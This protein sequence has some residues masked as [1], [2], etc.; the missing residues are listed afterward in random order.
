MRDVRAAFAA[1]WLEVAREADARGDATGGLR[2][3][4]HEAAVRHAL[5]SDIRTAAQGLDVRRVDSAGISDVVVVPGVLGDTVRLLVA[6]FSFASEPL[7]P[8]GIRT[9]VARVNGRTGCARNADLLRG[10]VLDAAAREGRPINLVGYSKGCTDALHMLARYPDTHAALHSLVSMAGVVRGTPLAARTP[11]W[12]SNA[13]RW[14]PL[15]GVP[16]GDGR[17]VADLTPA[18]RAAHLADHPLPAGIRYA[19]VV[20]A[21]SPGNVSRVLRGSWETLAHTEAGGRD[22]NDAQVIASDAVLPAGDLLARVD[23]DHWALVLPITERLPPARVLV[24]R[25]DFPRV[26]LLRALLEHVSLPDDAAACVDEVH[27]DGPREHRAGPAGT[28]R[29]SFRAVP[30]P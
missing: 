30:P 21:A 11:A 5:A 12:V 1:R 3:G 16:F 22:G 13:L 6:P 19:S 8:H 18:A 14:T 27:D 15:P 10:V 17:A 28:L 23:A 25:N 24:D 9:T 20:A 2:A 4:T 26:T 7:A 29:P